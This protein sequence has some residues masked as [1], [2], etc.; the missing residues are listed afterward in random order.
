VEDLKGKIIQKTDDLSKELEPCTIEYAQGEDKRFSFNR[1]Y[2]MKDGLSM[3]NPGPNNPD[4]VKPAGPVDYSVNLLKILDEKGKVKAVL[5]NHGNHCDT[6]YGE[7]I[8]GDWAAYLTKKLWDEFGDITV[9]VLNGSEGDVNHFDVMNHRVIQ[10]LDEAK[11]IG[12]GYAET[13]IAA[14]K[15]SKPIHVDKVDA[16]LETIAIP[17]RAISEEEYAEARK[18]VDSLKDDPKASLEGKTLE[19]QHIV[20]RHPAVMLMFA[21][22][23]VAAYDKLQQGDTTRSVSMDAIRIGDVVIVGIGG[24]PFSQIGI[25]IKKDSQFSH[26]MIAV[27]ALDT[28]GYLGTKDC[29]TGGGYETMRGE[30]VCDNA[31]D[32]VKE[33]ASRLLDKVKF[34]VVKV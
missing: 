27:C 29:Y 26:T 20:Q 28:A 25:D 22:E 12:R 11:M 15:Q 23:V 21:R 2:V 14:L 8:S 24:E 34:L 6:V 9:L 3:T 1:R 18:T 30:R 31:E 19:S 32:Y 4:V 16:A 10:N 13:A 7:H 33:A 5:F 17:K